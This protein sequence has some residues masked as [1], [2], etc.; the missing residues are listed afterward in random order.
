MQ[1]HCVCSRAE[2]NAIYK[3]DQQQPPPSAHCSFHKT[4]IS[5]C[6]LFWDT[7][8]QYLVLHLQLTLHDVF[9]RSLC[10]KYLHRS[11]VKCDATL[12]PC[13]DHP[14]FAHCSL[15]QTLASVCASFP[16]T[17]HLDL[18][19]SLQ[20]WHVHMHVVQV[21]VWNLFRTQQYVHN[22]FLVTLPFLFFDTKRTSPRWK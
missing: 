21:H 5:V 13:T 22:M 8:H 3:S 17:Y 11:T 9:C 4:L 16:N 18:V 7:H 10:L 6:T 14:P 2:N 20:P 1:A 15:H 19:L 12:F